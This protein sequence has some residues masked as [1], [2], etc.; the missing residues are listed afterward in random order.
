M[1]E[2]M[3]PASPRR[4][5][6]YRGLVLFALVCF[7]IGIAAMGWVLSEWQPVRHLVFGPQAEAPKTPVVD[8]SLTQTAPPAANTDAHMARIEQRLAIIDQ[9]ADSALNDAARAERLMIAF[10]ARRAVER[11]APLGYLEGALQ[12]QFGAADP[13]AVAAVI[14]GARSSVTLEQLEDG[15][16]A[17]KTDLASGTVGTGWLASI[18]QDMSSLA[19]VHRAGESSKT[20][21]QRLE[22]A[23]RALERDRVETAVKEVGAMPGAANAKP[24]LD[25]AKRYV[26]VRKALDRLE[27]ITLSVAPSAAQ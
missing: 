24:W 6:P 11:G 18:W 9:Q 20:P 22:T 21:S 8:T 5:N 4:T 14:D 16:E 1:D 26:A 25:K 17:E 2:E 10:A 27:A 23:R 15:L 12:R 13:A 19:V 7:V 3:T